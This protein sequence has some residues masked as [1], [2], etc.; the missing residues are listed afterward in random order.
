MVDAGK[1][2]PDEAKPT[3]KGERVKGA[4]GKMKNKNKVRN[5][6]KGQASLAEMYRGVAQKGAHKLPPL[7]LDGRKDSIHPLDINDAELVA[8]AWQINPDLCK[9]NL[10]AAIKLTMKT[11][12]DTREARRKALTELVADELGPVIEREKN[13]QQRSLDNFRTIGKKDYF[14]VVKFITGEKNWDRAL[15][16]IKRWEM[17]R[18]ATTEDA[19]EKAL[20]VYKN[21]I[22]TGTQLMWLSGD[23]RQWWKRVKSKK[24][25]AA[26]HARKGGQGRV[27]RRKSDLR[28]KANRRH[29]QGY[30]RKCGKRVRPRERLCDDCL[31]GKPILYSWGDL[32]YLRKT[33]EEL[34]RNVTGRY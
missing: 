31:S 25:K 20:A 8:L 21:E 11:L 28:F 5:D 12:L 9:T 13:E 16:K 14:C 17:A 7:S 26:A 27:K 19:V 29:K 15:D 6:K 30:C 24:A 33:Q 3:E 10:F 23:F 32:D 2:G 1:R 22:F 34:T 4:R 18:G